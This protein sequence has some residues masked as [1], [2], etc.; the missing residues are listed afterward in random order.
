MYAEDQDRAAQ[1]V[2]PPVVRGM[3][4]HHR[5]PSP[6]LLEGRCGDCRLAVLHRAVGVGDDGLT[7]AQA[8]GA[9][10][11]SVT[12]ASPPHPRNRLT[13]AFRPILAL[14]HAVLVGPVYWWVRSGTVGLLGAVTY[15]L[16]IVGWFSILFTGTHPGP[17]R[18][19][20][21]FYLRWRAR[22]VGYMCLLTDTYPPFGDG[23]YPI[24]VHVI[25]SNEPRDRLRVG[26]RI[27]LVIPH[28]IALC[29][30]IIAWLVVTVIGWIAIV[31]TGAHPAGLYEFAASML[32][33]T[34]QVEAYMLLLVDRYP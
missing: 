16:A 26:L 25:A 8:A 5:L 23:P 32:R 12:I 1:R 2:R 21:L 19:L 24:A 3:A 14:P 18:D 9:Y 33:W 22:A 34:I 15:F 11:V 27:L 17:M 10:P 13:T 28:F 6:H 20:A 7:V 4:L 29:F 31:L 30:L